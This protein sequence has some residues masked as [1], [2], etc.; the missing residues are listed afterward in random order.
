VRRGYRIAALHSA[1]G[2]QPS[3]EEA[4]GWLPAQRL[5]AEVRLWDILWQLVS[6]QTRAGHPAVAEAQRLIELRL[7]EVIYVTDL[8]KA[9]G[10]SQNH[11]TRLFAAQ[12]GKTVAAYIRDRR[13]E[14]AAHLLRHSTLPIKAIASEVGIPDLHLFN[15]SLRAAYGTAPRRLRRG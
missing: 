13:V 3:F 7:G 11:L 1:P 8:A 15:K 9:A 10:L 6:A 4:I 14:R 5:R 12:T 2:L